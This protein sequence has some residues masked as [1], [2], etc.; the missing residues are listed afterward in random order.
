MN[1]PLPGN[2][3]DQLL[4]QTRAHHVQLSAMAD[5]KA[6][7]MLTLASLIITFCIRYL[8]DPVLRWPVATLIVF[9]LATIFAAAYAVMPKW[10]RPKHLDL[11]HPNCDILFFGNFIHFT[12]VEY[13]EVMEEIMSDPNRVYEAQLREIYDLGVFLAEKKYRYIRISYI[14]FLIGLACSG[15]FF[16]VMMVGSSA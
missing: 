6:N 3:I 7:M 1:V 9:C 11:K 8:T 4:R 13:V 12:F 5:I 16:L 10:L 14:A 15:L 2:H